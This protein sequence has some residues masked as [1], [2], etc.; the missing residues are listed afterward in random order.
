MDEE[1]AVG[2]IA[3]GGPNNQVHYAK[4]KWPSI[5]NS[6]STPQALQ[7]Y[8]SNYEKD[9]MVSFLGRLTY[10]YKQKYIFGASVRRDGS[11][12]FG[13]GKPWQLVRLGCSLTNHLW[14]GVI[15]WIL[16]RFVVAGERPELNLQ[17]VI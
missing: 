16:E 12:K 17:L 2:G 7:A 14:I 11:S 6:G 10:S 15:G 3:K 1:H 9:V 13:K 8:S 5:D 4:N